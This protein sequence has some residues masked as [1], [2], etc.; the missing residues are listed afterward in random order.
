MSAQPIEPVRST[1]GSTSHASPEDKLRFAAE[2]L[3]VANL[4]PMQAGA[5][6]ERL[7]YLEGVEQR[8]REARDSDIWISGTDAAQWILTGEEPSYVA[9]GEGG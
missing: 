9:P 7:A 8:A 1:P 6:L 2:H 5:L 4:G 3:G